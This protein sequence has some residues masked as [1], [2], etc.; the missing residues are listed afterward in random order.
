MFLLPGWVGGHA[1]DAVSAVHDLLL[2]L[3]AWQG[4]SEL[5]ATDGEQRNGQAVSHA[6]STF[7]LA[8][9]FGGEAG[10]NCRVA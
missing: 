1:V 9:S 4:R 3:A 5:H 7:E 2:G 6:R 8:A 10:S